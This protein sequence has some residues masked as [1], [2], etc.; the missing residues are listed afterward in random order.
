MTPASER[1]YSVQEVARLWR[2]SDDTVRRTFSGE[3]GVLAIGN[4][5]RALLRIPE[6]VLARVH[7]RMSNGE[8]T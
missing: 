7:R 1:H 2:V 6:S 8:N 5:K 3:P 4:G